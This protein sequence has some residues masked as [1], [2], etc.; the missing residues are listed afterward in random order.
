ML[1]QGHTHDEVDALFKMINTYL[2]G[3]NCHSYQEFLES[4]KGIIVI[5]ISFF[6]I[7]IRIIFY[8]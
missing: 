7:T 8:Y 5:I 1:P 6:Y 4:L 3:N 2:A